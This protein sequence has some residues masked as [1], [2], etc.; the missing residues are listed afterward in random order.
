[1]QKNRNLERN[2]VNK[3][4]MFLAISLPLALWFFVLFCCL[5]FQL[6]LDIQYEIYKNYNGCEINHSSLEIYALN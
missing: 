3:K 5:F 6:Y 4:V 2:P 1:M